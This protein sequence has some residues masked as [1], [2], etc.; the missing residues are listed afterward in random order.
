MLS[1]T[2]LEVLLAVADCGGFSGA[3]KKLYMSQPSVS[4]NIRNLESSLG[5]HLV[6]RST[7]GAST[8]P[9][10]D[11][12]VEHARKVF[13]LL[14]SLEHQVADFQGLRAG[15]LVV[16]GTTTPG[17]YLLP[18]LVA[19]FSR[20]APNVGCQIRVAN[21]D[22]VE[23]WLLQGEVALGLC[24]AL[25]REEQLVA[26]PIF[27]E[28]MLLVAAAGS[29]LAG[30]PLSPEDLA[31]QR[32]LM[33]EVGSATRRQQEEAL[34]LWDL[35]GAEQWD[36]WGTETLKQAAHAGLGIALLPDHATARERSAGTLVALS[37][38]PV[39][40]GRTVYLVRRGDRIL[41]PPEEAFSE[42]VHG[43]TKWPQ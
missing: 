43:L 33:R 34:R 40:A 9:A 1:L 12:V 31:G 2:Q 35:D 13:A 14:G 32:F 37:V 24:A 5:V 36:L 19:E 11:V 4:N 21:Q 16:A 29:S 25:P 23:S 17:A 20:R 26:V 41:T 18:Q 3:A 6:Q 39:P 10:G 38:Q 27:D 8:T 22:T 15:R 28:A 42:L 7:Q 30:R